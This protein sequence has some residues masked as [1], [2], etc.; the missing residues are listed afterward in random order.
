[1]VLPRPL[2][3]CKASAQGLT[4]RTPAGTIRAY[5]TCRC[6]FE[7]ARTERAVAATSVLFLL[8]VREVL[9]YVP[10][11]GPSIAPRKGLGK[12]RISW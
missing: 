7:D 1:M 3:R 8:P 6:P 2:C 12:M 9:V 11:S 5:I 4:M 10:L